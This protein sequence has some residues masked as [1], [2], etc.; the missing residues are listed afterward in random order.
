MARFS[1][2][3]PP[4][5]TLLLVLSLM[6]LGW[7]QRAKADAPPLGIATGFDTIRWHSDEKLRAEME[8]YA[9]AGATWFR[10]DLN[11]SVVQPNSPRRYDWAPVDRVIDAAQAAG[12]KVLPVVS[13]APE[14]AW[15]GDRYSAPK[16]PKAF[17]TFLTAAVRRYSAKGIHAWEIWNEPNLRGF[18]PSPNPEDYARLLKA[19][20]PAIKR[21][22]H[23]AIVI[24]GGLSPVPRTDWLGEVDHY[25]AVDF[26][27]GI[28]AAGAGDTFDALGFHPYSYPYQPSETVS[29]SGW[30]MMTGPIRD[31]MIANGDA[32]KQIWLTEFGAPTHGSNNAVTEDEQAQMLTEAMDLLDGKSWAGPVFWYGY[33]D[34]GTG[35]DN[36]EDWFGL[37]TQSGREKPALGV[38]RSLATAP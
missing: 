18:W 10:T 13:F 20:Y 35:R 9:A 3:L 23:T 38:F 37:V 36:P 16:D 1:A 29:W 24:A 26:V 12:L 4:L 14:W 15:I 33:N 30:T 6:G 34:R 5:G 28:Y 22:D 8:A 25:S 27:R 7:A 32:K 11:W 2:K 19:A 17:A 31:L 21:V